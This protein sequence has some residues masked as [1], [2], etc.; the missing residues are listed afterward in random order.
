MN[1]KSAIIMTTIWKTFHPSHLFLHLP[2]SLY[3]F[4]THNISISI[5]MGHLFSISYVLNGFAYFLHHFTGNDCQCL[6]NLFCKSQIF[7]FSCLHITPICPKIPRIHHS[8]NN[9]HY[10]IY[11][12]P[13]L[14]FFLDV[15]FLGFIALYCHLDLGNLKPI[16]HILFSCSISTNQLM[17]SSVSTFMTFPALKVY[18]SHLAKTSLP[19]FL[20]YC[21]CVLAEQM[22]FS[23]IFDCLTSG[24]ADV[25]N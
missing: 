25:P 14:I 15:V 19:L 6:I 5:N 1:W 3:S 7:L 17:I 11:L 23:G 18:S 21:N 8:P 12:E 9:F 4:K 16:F 13:N 10:S 22:D 2:S 20:S 24:C